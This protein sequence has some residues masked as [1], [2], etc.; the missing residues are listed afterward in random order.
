MNMRRVR[1]A[2]AGIAALPAFGFLVGGMLSG[3][4]VPLH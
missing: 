1:A 2:V 3:Q 4:P